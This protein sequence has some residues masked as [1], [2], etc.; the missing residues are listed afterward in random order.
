MIKNQL[1]SFALIFALF[2]FDVSRPLGYFFL[3][4]LSFLAVI[5]VTFYG[6]LYFCLA[7]SLLLGSFQDSIIFSGKLFYTFLYPLTALLVS[8]L[9][10]YFSFLR[11]KTHPVV[12]KTLLAGI[13]LSLYTALNQLLSGQNNFILSLYFF[14]Q[15]YLIFFPLDYFIRKC[16]PDKKNL[17]PAASL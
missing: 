15:S 3:P 10:S 7:V 9:N 14:V 4:S 16:F 8:F 2:I 1:K 13:L 17:Q 12:A 6:K 5:S 11:L